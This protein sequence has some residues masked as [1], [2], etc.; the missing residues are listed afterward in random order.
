ME[1][2][3]MSLKLVVDKEMNRVV[4]AKSS[5][6]FVDVLFSF[7]TMLMG[8]IV[9]LIGKESKMGGIT[10]LYESVKDLDINLLQTNS[11]K[12]MLLYPKSASEE[13]CNNRKEFRGWSKEREKVQP[14]NSNLGI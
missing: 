6:D 1:G 4:F 8:T 5:N 14:K 7:L 2:N 13:H 12:K 11:C 3:Q 9:R 10:T